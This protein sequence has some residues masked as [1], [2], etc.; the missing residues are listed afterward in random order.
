MP[1]LPVNISKAHIF[2]IYAFLAAT[3]QNLNQF[4]KKYY[5]RI[6]SNRIEKIIIS[7]M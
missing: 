7:I 3:K 4:H 5:P 6:Q 1:L 2:T